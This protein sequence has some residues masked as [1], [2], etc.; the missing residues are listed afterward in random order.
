M[1]AAPGGA[2]NFNPSSFCKVIPY[3]GLINENYFKIKQRESELSANL[4]TFKYITKNPFSKKL[5][6]FLGILIKSKYDGIG[7]EL[8]TLDISIALDISGSMENCI[9]TKPTFKE[10]ALEINKEG[11]EQHNNSNFNELKKKDRLTIAK[12]CLF[13]MIDTM[14]DKVQMALT[15]FNIESKQIICLSPKEELKSISNLINEIKPGGGTDLVVALKG[16]AECLNESTS[17]FKRV[18]IITD[19]WNNNSNFMDVAKQLNEKNI[20]ITVISID[21]SANSSLYE[22][23]SEIKGCNYYFILNENDMEKY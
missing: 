11:K 17:K 1:G 12:E 6:Y 4:E 15:T 9:Q 5:D 18:I 13:K 23:L 22:K 19:G 14:S 16:A 3:E 7:R 20:L 2:G 8:D 10:L 21:P